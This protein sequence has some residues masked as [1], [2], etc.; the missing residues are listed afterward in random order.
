[1]PVQ[2][3]TITV[4]LRDLDGS[5]LAGVRIS[6][7]LVGL[8]VD[9]EAAVAPGLIGGATDA[10]GTAT[11]QLW[12]NRN[13]LS[14]TYYEISSFHPATGRHIHRRDRFLVVDADADV[15][16]LIDV[17]YTD[18]GVPSGSLQQVIAYVNSASASAQQSAQIL[19]QILQLRQQI[20]DL[21]DGIGDIP[22]PDPEALEITVIQGSAMLVPL[23]PISDVN[24]LIGYSVTPSS[25]FSITGNTAL[26]EIQDAGQLS[27]VLTITSGNGAQSVANVTVTAISPSSVTS[28]SAT[29]ISV[30]AGTEYSL[31]AV[32]V[33]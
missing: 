14:N 27:Y 16:D 25:G 17:G 10:N 1:M 3:R 12:E 30:D 19:D 32:E 23:G 20:Q 29:N 31:P 2:T 9:Y 21:I 11:F 8:G 28:Y 13:D 5:P 4:K 24:G 26:I 6:I 33:A 22:D 18:S 15:K 7:N